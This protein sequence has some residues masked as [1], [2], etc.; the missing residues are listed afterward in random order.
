MG[1]TSG[2]F[3]TATVPSSE[4]VKSIINRVEDEI[5]ELTQQAWRLRQVTESHGLD[6]AYY[7]RTGIP[8]NLYHNNVR[9]LSATKGDKL[10]VFDGSSNTYINW[11]TA[12][13][14]GRLNDYWFDYKTGILWI[15]GQRYSANEDMVRITYRYGDCG[16]AAISGTHTSTVQTITVDST[17]DFQ[18]SGTIR[19]DGSEEI[20]YTGKTATTFTGCTRASNGTTNAAYTGNEEVYQ[21]NKTIERLATLMTVIELLTTNFRTNL[22]AEGGSI[23]PKDALERFEKERDRL[24]VMLRPMRIV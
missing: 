24:L 15:L 22:V 12:K 23:G 19:I 3:T 4:T 17:A 14:E 10:E 1:L 9:T 21:V 11:L 2:H 16:I 13:T 8:V 6:N 18:P 20:R 7:P 5:D